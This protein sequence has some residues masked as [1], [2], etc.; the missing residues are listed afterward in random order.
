MDAIDLLVNRTSHGKLKAPGPSNEQLTT[1]LKAALRAPDHACLK[2]WQYL[3]YEGE[4]ALNWLGDLFAQAKQAQDPNI[5]QEK[6]DRA[7][8][9]PLRAPMVIIAVAKIKDHPK[10]P[11]VEQIISAGC[12]VH[13]ML[14]AAEAMGLGGYWRSGELNY[15]ADLKRLLELEESDEIAG[16]LYLGT[17]EYPKRALKDIDIDDFVEF[18]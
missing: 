16:F 15:S 12:G 3:V 2:P 8:S 10:V 11:A 1:M 7:R 18:R 13:S 6:L 4:E 5:S 14:L 9:L 17:P